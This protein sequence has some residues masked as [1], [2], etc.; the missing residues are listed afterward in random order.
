[1][2][3]MPR[4]MLRSA[5]SFFACLG[6]AASLMLA[7]GSAAAQATPRVAGDAHLGV[8]SCAGSTCH[9]AAVP[10]RNSPVLQNEFV[11]WQKQDR[12]AQAYKS[13]TSE[14]GRRIAANLGLPNASEA[15]LCL[16]C[17]TDFVPPGQRSRAFAL[18]DGVGCEACHGGSERWLGVHLSGT[19]TRA[20]NLAAGMYPLDDPAARGKLC[21]GCHLGSSDRWV[22][23]RIMGAGHPRLRFELDTFTAAQ[24]AHYRVDQDYRA[25]KRVASPALTWMIGQALTAQGFIDA[26]TDP[27]HSRSGMFPELTFYDC[28]SCHHLMAEKRY[29]PAKDLPTQPGEPRVQDANLVLLRVI[30]GVMDAPQAAAYDAALRGLHEASQQ[31]REAQIRAGRALKAEVDRMLPRLMREPT[32]AEARQLV[33]RLNTM[34][35]S[36]GYRGYA[37]AEQVVMALGAM[38]A[39]ARQAGALVEPQHKRASA[40]LDRLYKAVENEVAFSAAAYASAVRELAGTMTSF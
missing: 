18:S 4:Q 9:G 19:N 31:G 5:F 25:R 27:K 40:A 30:A 36:P 15:P 32:R 17:H 38:V 8:A 10:W 2:H 3:K 33:D 13:L 24:P 28:H 12:H 7:A 16:G 23:H 35:E 22:T 6:V 14:A 26:L 37:T 29:E 39:H 21:L 11:T 20:Q 1:M 34:A